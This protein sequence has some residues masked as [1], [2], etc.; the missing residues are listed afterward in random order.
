MTNVIH[1]QEIEIISVAGGYLNIEPFVVP[2]IDCRIV[3]YVVYHCCEQGV[4]HSFTD[5]P[6]NHVSQVDVTDVLVHLDCWTLNPKQE[7]GAPVYEW[8]DDPCAR[9]R[10]LRN[11]QIE[12]LKAGKKKDWS[13]RDSSGTKA[14][15]SEDCLKELIAEADAECDALTSCTNNRCLKVSCGS[16]YC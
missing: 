7:V 6:I 3:G 15:L 16:G 5:M 12:W 9:L 1:T 14:F 4:I 8:I 13:W 2:N 10:M 11:C